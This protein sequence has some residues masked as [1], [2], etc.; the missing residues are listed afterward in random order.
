MKH[1]FFKNIDFD[2]L[3]SGKGK[4]PWCPSQDSRPLIQRDSQTGAIKKKANF[5]AEDGEN[6]QEMSFDEGHFKKFLRQ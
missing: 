2:Q 3:K 1:G 5:F 6:N 4:A